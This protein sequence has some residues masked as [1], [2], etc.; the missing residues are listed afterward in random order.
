M[1]DFDLPT[2]SAYDDPSLKSL[3]VVA[4]V[5]HQKN[6]VFAAK[7]K[8]GGGSGLKW[9]FPGGK[10]ETG[11]SAEAALKREILEELN[12]SVKVGECLG[13]FITPLD[14]RIIHLQ[15]FWCST[16]QYDFKLS[17]HID[18]GWYKHE[19]L[20]TLDWAPPDVE[21]VQH[22]ITAMNK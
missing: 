14:N 22:V 21:A 5:I 11:E 3:W 6:Q 12:V 15:C 17:S 13:T 9:E 10:V 18:A 4:A 7:R 2:N 19:E 20:S 16:N 1:S 8:A